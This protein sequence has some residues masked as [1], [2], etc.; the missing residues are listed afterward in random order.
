[1]YGKQLKHMSYK[2][3]HSIFLESI[4]AFPALGVQIESHRGLSIPFTGKS[5][6]LSVSRRFLSMDVIHDVLIN[7]GLRHWDW[8][9]YLVVLRRLPPRSEDPDLSL[10]VVFE[11]RK[12]V[13]CFNQLFNA[14]FPPE[15]STTVR[16][17]S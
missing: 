13:Q 3:L 9:Y 17:S 15:Y 8:K 4:I 2:K 14:F 16:S 5:I 12:P 10:F 7:E 6:V 11:V 1:M